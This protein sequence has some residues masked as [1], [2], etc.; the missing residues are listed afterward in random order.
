MW[1]TRVTD[2]AIVTRAG[3]A[4]ITSPMD[5]AAGCSAGSPSFIHDGGSMSNCCQMSWA[6]GAMGGPFEPNNTD[7]VRR[8][9]T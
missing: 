7:T 6:V 4:A 8:M 3:L 5:A 2:V 1:E 9:M